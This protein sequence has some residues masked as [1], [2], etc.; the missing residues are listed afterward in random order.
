[1]KWVPL[2]SDRGWPFLRFE[3]EWMRRDYKA[4]SFFGCPAGDE[5]E[6]AGCDE[7]FALRGDTLE[8]WGGYA[9]LLWGFRRG[10]AAGLRFEYAT[11]DGDSVG[12][13][14]SRDD[15]P[16]RDDRTRIS[17]LLVWYP[18]EFSRVRFQYNYDRAD[19]LDG[20]DAHT[21]WM[22]LEFLIGSHPAHRF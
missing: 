11:G 2:S 21:F 8:D 15:D 14:E 10:W 22:G 18:S 1:M 13:F 3:A 9:Q 19:F 20:D 5:E 4:D 16:F 6:E 12:E 7:P 17:P